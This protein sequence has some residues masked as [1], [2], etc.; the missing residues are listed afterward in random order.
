MFSSSL[1]LVN[2]TSVFCLISHQWPS[3]PL[4][5]C[6]RFTSDIIILLSW[7]IFH[8][9]SHILQYK[10]LN[11]TLKTFYELAPVH[12]QTLPTS[13]PA[14]AQ[15]TSAKGYWMTCPVL[16]LLLHMSVPSDLHSS[17][18][19]VSLQHFILLTFTRDHLIQCLM[20]KR[21]FREGK[22]MSTAKYR[23]LTTFMKSWEHN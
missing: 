1:C 12:A 11:I 20:K 13:I 4:H 5:W 10:L 23:I 3:L 8:G 22:K 16:I 2:P 15:L 7:I 17:S 19:N 14:K 21:D 18:H 6:E 9:P